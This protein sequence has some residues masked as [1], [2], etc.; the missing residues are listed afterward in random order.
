MSKRRRLRV[1]RDR[2]VWC[3]HCE[4]VH[5]CLRNCFDHM[6]CQTPGC[7]GSM[8]DLNAWS[9]NKWPRNVYPE[10]PEIPQDGWVYSLYESWQSP[11][12]PHRHKNAAMSTGNTRSGLVRASFLPVKGGS[13]SG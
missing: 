6:R 7:D 3:L 13:D 10:Y 12:Y 11:Q 1:V 5:K 8:F 9:V 2:Y 4:R